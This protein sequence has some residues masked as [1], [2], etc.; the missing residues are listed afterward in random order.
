MT[1]PKESWM[2]VSSVL[3]SEMVVCVGE[4]RLGGQPGVAVRGWSC[5]SCLGRTVLLTRSGPGSAF[6]GSVLTFIASN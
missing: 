3:G 2:I 1:R 6:G 4:A 5:G